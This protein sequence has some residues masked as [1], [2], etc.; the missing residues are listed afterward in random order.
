MTV[1]EIVEKYLGQYKE[2]SAGNLQVKKCPFCDREKGKFYIKEDTGVYICH[3]GSCGAKGTLPQLVKHLEEKLGVKIAEPKASKKK[4]GDKVNLQFKKEDIGTLFNSSGTENEG[5]KETIEYINSRGISTKTAR[6]M[7]VF[8][9]K[10]DKSVI[11]AY[12]NLDGNLA[13]VKY[14][15]IR[16]KKFSQATGSQAYLWNLERATNK[17]III[18]EGEMEALTL[19]EIGLMDRALSVPMGVGNLDWIDNCREFLESKEEIILAFDNDDAGEKALRKVSHR[20]QHLNIR[21]IDLGAYKDINEFFM[22]EGKD[23]LIKVLDNSKEIELQGL[24]TFYEV[25]RHDINK[26]DR[27]PFGIDTLDRVT[28]GAKEGELIILA[29]DNGSGKAQPLHSKIYTPN[30]Y[31][32][33]GDIKLGD[34][35]YDKDGNICNVTGIFPQ[36]IKERYLVK[37][38]DGS[39]AECCNEHLWV[40]NTVNNIKKRKFDK[41]QI[42]TLKEIMKDGLLAKSGRGYKYFIPTQKAIENNEIELPVDPYILGVLIGDGYIK[43]R[44]FFSTNEKD[45]VEKVRNKLPK[46]HIIKKCSEKNYSYLISNVENSKKN[47]IIKGLRTLKLHGKGSEEKFIPEIYFKSSIKQ[48]QELLKGLFDTDGYIAKNNSKSI[49]TVSE[50][51]KNDIMRL[52]HSLGYRVSVTEDSRTSKYNSGHCFRVCIWTNDVIFSTE[53]HLSKIKN[54]TK[55]ANYNFIAIKSIERLEPVEMQCIMVDSPSHTYLT[56]NMIITHNTLI[57]KQFILNARNKGKKVLVVN[58]EIQN[59]IYK[60]DLF[61]QANGDNKLVKTEDIL[62]RGEYDYRVSDEN[63]QM[64]NDWL[65]GYLYT[66]SDQEELTDKNV[67]SMIESSI[68]KNN[69]FFIVVDN[70]SVIYCE[71]ENEAEA[72]GRFAVALKNLAKKHGVCILLVNHFT[73]GAK[74]RGKEG[75]KGSGIIS[76]IA[77]MVFISEREDNPDIEANGYLNVVKNRLNGKLQK[78]SLY[79]NP[80]YK[81]LLDDPDKVLKFNWKEFNE[82]RLELENEDLPY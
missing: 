19:A 28:R 64:I 58:G 79:F 20:L 9:R 74:D 63:Y 12:K 54:K 25:G 17:K 73:K 35:V 66:M 23:E 36:G 5:A 27:F 8:Y 32:R 45:L 49:T 40:V 42:K 37:L 51:L 47:S 21:K 70:L 62:I 76:D 18:G 11:F 46:N 1:R 57:S 65:N 22:F 82:V 13:G 61:K 39:T 14:R 26:L 3:S 30:G 52:C 29:G 24:E 60:E 43:Q 48:R 80:I 55:E 16:E 50:N 72:K 59:E 4:K 71:G 31:I 67:L 33:M 81:T 6:D 53:K 78:I 75:I 15:S 56:D 7:D 2:V 38:K 41:L 69:V 44:C 10:S 68:I 77:D 34:K